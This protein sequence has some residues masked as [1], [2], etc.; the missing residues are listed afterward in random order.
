MRSIESRISG[1]F[2]VLDDELRARN[3]L[4]CTFVD[5]GMR[6]GF[7]E[8]RTTSVELRERYLRAT[9]VASSK[10]FEVRRPKEGSVYA[11]QADLAMS[12][13]R[14]IADLG[15]EAPLKFVQV[16]SMFRDR[17]PR[18]RHFRREF[19]Q[20]LLGVW[21]VPDVSADADVIAATV[22]ALALVPAVRPSHVLVSNHGFFECLSP[23]LASAVRFDERGLD[24]LADCELDPADRLVLSEL[25]AH[26]D[27]SV[28]T[29]REYVDRFSDQRLCR[30][31]EL[32]EELISAL[33]SWSVTVP[34]RFSLSNLSGTGHYSGLTFSVHV[35]VGADDAVVAIS[36]GGRIDTLCTRL[37]G[38]S[39][40]ATCLGT[41]V[42]VLAQLLEV[43]AERR[44]A[45]VLCDD[46]DGGA[47]PVAMADQLRDADVDVSFLKL[48]RPRW[49]M[50]LRSQFYRDCMFVLHDA[51]GTEVR[52]DHAADK[53]YIAQLLTTAGYAVRNG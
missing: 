10:I 5:V 1:F 36:D 9:D 21:G 52:G 42:T 14:F 53:R 22:E 3:L 38:A 13:S 39:I 12:M 35:R 30:E 45:V 41:G 7:R 11:L 28:S 16:G 18:A 6:F 31:A 23:G 47:V 8:I 48:P 37:T 43:G 32:V 29:F 27:I 49:R 2:D 51:R 34:V 4:A 24:V 19:E 46:A 26:E 50:V 40:P 20:A 44:S 33:E 25:F 15:G 17:P